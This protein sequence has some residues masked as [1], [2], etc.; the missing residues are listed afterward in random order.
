MF[1]LRIN[2]NMQKIR[3]VDVWKLK[4]KA[5]KDSLRVLTPNEYYRFFTAIDNPDHAFYFKILFGTGMRIEEARQVKIRNINLDRRE[6]VVI[7]SKT[8]KYGSKGQR[9]VRF[10]SMLKVRTADTSLCTL[11]CASAKAAIWGR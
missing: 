7:R 5:E 1:T 2:V 8:G 3:Q 4:P 6:I 11:K 10:S 9:R